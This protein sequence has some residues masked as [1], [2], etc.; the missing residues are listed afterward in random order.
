MKNRIARFAKHLVYAIIS[1]ILYGLAVYYI[2]VS[3]IGKSLLYVYLVNLAL[4]ILFLAIDKGA[5]KMWESKKIIM[6]LKKEKDMERSYRY[7]QL[8]FD[9]FVSFKT[10]LYLFY[11]IILIA[12]QIID[13][14][15]TAINENLKNFIFAN[16]YSIILLL[17]ADELVGQ[18]TKDRERIRKISTKIKKELNEGQE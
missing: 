16:N 13:F 14:Y 6:A 10:V 3:L 7:I 15:P 8:Y 2:Y 5:L 4:I 9:A 18:F 12:A 1:N 17:A 11:I